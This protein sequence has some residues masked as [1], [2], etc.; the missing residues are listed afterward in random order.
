MSIFGGPLNVVALRVGLA[1]IVAVNTGLI[2]GHLQ[3]KVGI[4]NL[5]AP[6]VMRGLDEKLQKTD[7]DSAPKTWS[8]GRR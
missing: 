8:A 4:A 7:D 1:F 6:I 3:R 2:V 5:L